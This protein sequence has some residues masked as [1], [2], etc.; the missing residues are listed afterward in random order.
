MSVYGTSRKYRLRQAKAVYGSKAD[1]GKPPQGA[2]MS[3]RPKSHP[4]PSDA[5][6]L[7]IYLTI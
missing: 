7:D 1:S 4:D 5:P 3:S 6:L 2:F